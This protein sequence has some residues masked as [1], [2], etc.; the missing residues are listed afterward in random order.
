MLESDP[1]MKRLLPPLCLAL[2]AILAQPAIPARAQSGIVLRTFPL[3]AGKLLVDPTRPQLYATLPADNSLA[4]INTD[5]NTVVTTFFIGSDPVDLTIS[6]DGN[7]LYVANS[8]STSAGIGVV[9]LTS[10]TVLPSLPAP[11]EPAAIAAGLG[12]RLYVLGNGSDEG[13]TMGLAQIDATTGTL[14]TMF[15]SGVTYY[16]G[17]LAITPDYSTLFYTDAGISAATLARFDVSTATPTLLQT[18]GFT[19]IGE[20]AEGIEIAH[21]GQ[22]LVFPNGGGNNSGGSYT[23]SL[24][25]TNNVLGVLGTFDTGVYPGIATFSVDDSKLYQ[26]Q[27]EGGNDNGGSVLKIFSTQTFTQLDSFDLPYDD[28]GY[29][30]TYTS[31]AVTSPNG[32]LYIASTASTFD[33]SAADLI[34]VSTQTAPFFNGASALSDGFFY[35]QFPDGNLFGYYN[36]NFTPYLYHSDLGFEYPFDAADGSGGIYLYDFKSSDFFYTSPALF[37]YLYDFNLNSFL[38]YYPDTKNPGHY[39]SNPRYFYNFATGK[40]ITK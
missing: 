32:Y 11:F 6:P 26:V 16:S 25:P 8:G 20:N 15:P 22:F 2:L 7:T 13:G 33:G 31:L 38:Y 36:F 14:Q 40:I 24:I 9:D 37:P 34:L 1:L 12:N 4:V 19:D 27:D 5:T 29:P 23:T 28:S 35:L 30:P 10:L 21:N 17:F 39:T 3:K 18:N